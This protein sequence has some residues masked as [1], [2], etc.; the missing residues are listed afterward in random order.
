MSLIL[1]SFEFRYQGE[2]IS[3][4]SRDGEGALVRLL[5]AIVVSTNFTCSTDC[6]R[7]S[8]GPLKSKLEQAMHG[9][10]LAQTKPVGTDRRAR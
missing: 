5:G 2:I 7:I 6:R 9:H 4:Y 3:R 8:A 1:T 10:V